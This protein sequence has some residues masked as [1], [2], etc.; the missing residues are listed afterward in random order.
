MR[1]RLEILERENLR[2]PDIQAVIEG[3]GALP[4]A[5][6]FVVRTCGVYGR[7]P[8]TVMM[9]RRKRSLPP[10]PRWGEK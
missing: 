10:G 2:L 5:R 6:A 4:G 8:K 3:L 1:Y 9:P 7:S